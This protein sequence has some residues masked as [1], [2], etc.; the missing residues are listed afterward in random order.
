MCKKKKKLFR[1]T[2]V[3]SV[4]PM[5][6]QTSIFFKKLSDKNLCQHSRSVLI[7]LSFLAYCTDFLFTFH[8]N[9]IS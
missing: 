6:L 2:Q 9:S 1:V 7:N 5:S 4:K 8:F 3:V